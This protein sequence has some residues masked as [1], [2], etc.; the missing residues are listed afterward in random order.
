M[1]TGGGGGGVSCCLGGL[2]LEILLV[3]ATAAVV[4]CARLQVVLH[5]TM[6][7]WLAK[8]RRRDMLV[9]DPDAA[10]VEHVVA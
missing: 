3:L 8:A 4:H 5:F 2:H 10:A 7:F 6:D 1:A 9:E